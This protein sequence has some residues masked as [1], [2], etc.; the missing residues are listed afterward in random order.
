[1]S[2]EAVRLRYRYIMYFIWNN[3]VGYIYIETIISS[4]GIH[5]CICNQTH[6]YCTAIIH[7][8]FYAL[9][10][11]RN[12]VIFKIIQPGYYHPTLVQWLS[13]AYIYI[14][15]LQQISGY[16]HYSLGYA[17]DILGFILYSLFLFVL[18]CKVFL[19]LHKPF[20]KKIFR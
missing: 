6:T 17:L 15:G 7:F 20:L 1:M 5:H 8:P 10:I 9:I 16:T 11:T 19:L 12:T 3:L 13:Q 14:F 2:H 4:T 18:L